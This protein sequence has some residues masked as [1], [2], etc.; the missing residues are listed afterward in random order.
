[1]LTMLVL[2][3]H[4]ALTPPSARGAHGRR[5][6]LSTGSLAAFGFAHVPAAFASSSDVKE[7]MMAK[8]K[9]RES[10]ESALIEA[11]G[12]GRGDPLTLKL[13][14]FR[15]QLK[16]EAPQQLE[17]KEWDNVRKVSTALLTQMTFSG[18]T[19]ESV[20][21][22][23]ESWYDAGDK[24]LSKEILVR[25]NILMRSISTL[26]N[27]LYAAQTNNKK[28]MLSPDDLQGAL[29]STVVALD[30]VID[31]MGCDRRW[32]SG[33]CEILPLAEN[34]GFDHKRVF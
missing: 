21:A 5:A 27:G 30:A 10:Q 22:R 20:K 18:Y 4:G 31:K 17:D 29:A 8:A 7:A 11:A 9:A 14:M 19:G 6:V 2:S 23:A 13:L 32:Q 34:A 25:R 26:E 3:T 15:E 24:V 28:T 1:M 33:R 16:K 12:G